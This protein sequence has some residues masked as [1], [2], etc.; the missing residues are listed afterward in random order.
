M[1]QNIQKYTDACDKKIFMKI[2]MHTTQK[3]M[4]ENTKEKYE[5]ESRCIWF[6]KLWMRIRYNVINI[7]IIIL[8]ILIWNYHLNTLPS[9][10][11]NS[12]F[13]FFQPFSQWVFKN[14]TNS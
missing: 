8:M 4:N 3:I 14:N 9:E 10:V 11:I 13:T 1:E 5:W 12:Y 7:L 2:Q 6:G